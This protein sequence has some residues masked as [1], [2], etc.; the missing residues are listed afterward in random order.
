MLVTGDYTYTTL[1]ASDADG[2]IDWLTEHGYD[3]SLL[4]DA[5]AGYVADP[6]DYEFV[7]V[8]LRP[9]VPALTEGG[10]VLQPLAITYGAAADGELHAVFP[11]KRA[12]AD[13]RSARCRA[14]VPTTLRPT[15]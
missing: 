1:A 13:G 7:A 14:T 15:V 6:L 9:D 5:V 11:A 3:V 4:A 8:Q 2:L 12:R 10:C